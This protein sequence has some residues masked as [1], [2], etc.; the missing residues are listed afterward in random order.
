MSHKKYLPPSKEEGNTPET[1][2]LELPAGHR[3][4]HL[5]SRWSAR[6]RR[7]T[8]LL[9]GVLLFGIATIFAL[10]GGGTRS[11]SGS[12][13]VLRSGRLA[14]TA[15]KAQS[16]TSPTLTATGEFQEYP[17]PQSDSQLMRPAIDHEGRLWFGEMGR[18]Y[19]AVFDPR[20][21]TFRQMIPPRGR[22]GVMSVQVASDDTIWFVEQ[23][24][25]Y[26]GHYFPTTGHYQVYPLPTL[27]VPDPSHAG[28]TLTLPS[29]PNELA[30]DARGTV[31]FT[32]FNAATL[33]RLDPRTGLI[34]HYPLAARRSV[35]ML[36]PYG[37]AVDPQGMI[38]FT[39]LSTDQV[40]R[41]DP[42]TGRIRFFLVPGSKVSLMEIASDAHG[43]IWVTSF[44]DELLLRLD[45]R[46]A[47]FT[48]YDASPTGNGTGGLYGLV[49]TPAGDV[50]V[51]MWADNMLAHLDVTA[52]RFVYYRI[53]TPGSKPLSMAL[54]PDQQTL[55]FNEVDKLGMVQLETG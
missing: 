43:T 31:W 11:S 10:A 7:D 35:Q 15:T 6:R 50:W 25:N 45:P 26:I 48:R 34:R 29:A 39:E 30:L 36:L 47:T 19:L 38:W 49:V 8:W 9:L 14:A 4:H 42:V 21:R 46:I 20:T 32:E 2:R 41:L 5:S 55:W 12:A 52:R 17:L 27:T 3:T 23:Y 40:G 13:N 54:G 16:I 18:N 51:T 28:K 53:P 33:G 37:V 44:E 1:G 24:A 22:F